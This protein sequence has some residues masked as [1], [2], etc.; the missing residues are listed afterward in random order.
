M[1]RNTRKR[2]DRKRPYRN[3]LKLRYILKYFV[4]KFKIKNEK[5]MFN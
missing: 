5:N 3:C 4:F 1:T 2:N